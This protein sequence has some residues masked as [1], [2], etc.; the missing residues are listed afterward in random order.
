[1]TNLEYLFKRNSCLN[2]SENTLH[3]YLEN[4][5]VGK[6]SLTS[7]DSEY[8]WLLQ[9]Y[10]EQILTDKEK[11]YLENALRPFKDRIVSIE[12]S[13]RTYGEFIRINL[14]SYNNEGMIESIDMPYFEEDTMY[15][16]MKTI[17]KY[18]LKELGLFCDDE[19]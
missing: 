19:I 12:K 8:N 16:G 11:Q 6:I 1:M 9:E 18:S 5:E 14:K 2:I 7:L 17:K 10:K 3:I 4:K 13:Y 15:K